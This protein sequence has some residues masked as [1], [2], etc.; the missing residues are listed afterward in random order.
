MKRRQS[1]YTPILEWILEIL[2]EKLDSRSGGIWAEQTHRMLKEGDPKFVHVCL[3]S[4]DS[5][6]PKKVISFLFVHQVA[7]EQ[8]TIMLIKMKQIL[9]S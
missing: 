1:T 5:G 2:Q 9:L 3:E 8:Q 7:L 6:E 4:Q